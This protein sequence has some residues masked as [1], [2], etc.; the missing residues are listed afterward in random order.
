M[1]RWSLPW[2]SSFKKDVTLKKTL[3]FKVTPTQRLWFSTQ[4]AYILWGLTL[5]IKTEITMV[6]RF[7]Q[8]VASQKWQHHS[9]KI[10]PKTRLALQEKR[11]FTIVE[12]K[13]ALRILLL[14]F[15]SNRWQK[16]KV[17]VCFLMWAVIARVRTK[18]KLSIESMTFILRKILQQKTKFKSLWLA[19]G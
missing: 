11:T 10:N 15:G 16:I 6:P 13:A 1:W 17:N 19:S 8:A 18:Y 5:G 3:G 4:S 12:L 7:I 9:L 2:T 14:K